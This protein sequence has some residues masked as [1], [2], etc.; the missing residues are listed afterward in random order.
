MAIRSP[1]PTR[2][3]TKCP[4]RDALMRFCQLNDVVSALY[5]DNDDS[6]DV[7]EARIEFSVCLPLR[8]DVRKSATRN[9]ISRGRGQ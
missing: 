6:L 7:N 9:A 3:R 8:A 5:L 4:L 1:F 2:M